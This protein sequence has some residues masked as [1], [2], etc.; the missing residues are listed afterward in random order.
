MVGLGVVISAAN[1]GSRRERGP[2]EV[3]SGTHSPEV[4][5]I[6]SAGPAGTSGQQAGCFPVDKTDVAKPNRFGCLCRKSPAVSLQCQ[7]QNLRTV[8]KPNANWPARTFQHIDLVFSLMP[9]APLS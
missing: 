5:P 8:P 7:P 6:D 9:G 3:E 4:W 2:E 1:G